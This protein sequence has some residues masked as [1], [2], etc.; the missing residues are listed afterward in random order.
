MLVEIRFAQHSRRIP[1]NI[2]IRTKVLLYF[3]AK[4]LLYEFRG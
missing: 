4:I 2:T 1:P 3:S